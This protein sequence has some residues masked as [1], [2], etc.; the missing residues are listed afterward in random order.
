MKATAGARHAGRDGTPKTEGAETI[1]L[2]LDEV[3]R[4][5]TRYRRPEHHTVRKHQ[6][7]CD[8]K[9]VLVAPGSAVFVAWFETHSGLHIPVNRDECRDDQL[10][11]ATVYRRTRHFQI[12][13]S[14]C[15]GSSNTLCT[16]FVVKQLCCRTNAQELTRYLML[17]PERSTELYQQAVPGIGSQPKTDTGQTP[18]GRLAGVLPGR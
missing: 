11:K 10:D 16:T 12:P 14:P 8:H 18:S 9:T 1:G 7:S 15:A 5:V 6:I 3:D 17:V 13:A 2:P 4:Q